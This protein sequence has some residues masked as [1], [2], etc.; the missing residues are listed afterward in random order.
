MFIYGVCLG[1]PNTG[2]LSTTLLP[3]I[4]ISRHNE[5]LYNLGIELLHCGQPQ[6]AFDCLLE[7]LQQYQVNP[8]LWLRL[9]EC[10]I[11]A[12]RAVRLSACH[13]RV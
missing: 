10:C 5:I 9:A 2:L 11:M 7:T 8:C 12:H 1:Q 13:N 3:N 4:G 6:L